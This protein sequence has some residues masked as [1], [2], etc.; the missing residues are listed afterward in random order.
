MV[1]AARRR[2]DR[3]ALNARGRILTAEET[4]D[5]CISAWRRVRRHHAP[6]QGEDG[7]MDFEDDGSLLRLIFPTIEG[8]A[9]L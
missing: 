6:S 3:S 4:A 9:R 7:R 2:I 8:G 5:V 1:L